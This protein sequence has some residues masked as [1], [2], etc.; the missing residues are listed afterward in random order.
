MEMSFKKF[1]QLDEETKTALGTIKYNEELNQQVKVKKMK[2]LEKLLRNFDFWYQYMDGDL[3]SWKKQNELSQEIM[4]LRVLI[5]K[6][7]DELFYQ[8]GKKQ[9]YTEAKG[10]ENEFNHQAKKREKK[11][12]FEDMNVNEKDISLGYSNRQV[13]EKSITASSFCDGG[14]LSENLPS[15]TAPSESTKRKMQYK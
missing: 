5:G 7:G 14:N 2:E 10:K 6:D 15:W 12:M 3:R 4:K 8:Y 1:L 13:G 11:S 9:N